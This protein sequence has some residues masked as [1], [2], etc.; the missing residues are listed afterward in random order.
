M[1]AVGRHPVARGHPSVQLTRVRPS[2]RRLL[3]VE[4]GARLRQSLAANAAESLR[5][6]VGDQCRLV[7]TAERLVRSDVGHGSENGRAELSK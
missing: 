3:H 5:A 2:A 7:L 4:V 1:R 6:G